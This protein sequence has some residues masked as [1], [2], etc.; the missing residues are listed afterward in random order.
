MEQCKW[1]E[2]IDNRIE[3]TE[4]NVEKLFDI[5]DKIRNRLPLWATILI[6]SLMAA[7]GYLV[8]M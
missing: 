2:A 1:H 7:I 3:T 8:K 4:K 6:S 5:T